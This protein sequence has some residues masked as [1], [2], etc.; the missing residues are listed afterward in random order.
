MKAHS[1]TR[2][3]RYFW[4]STKLIPNLREYDSEESDS[5]AGA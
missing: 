1:Q 5:E 2:R 3:A 4:T